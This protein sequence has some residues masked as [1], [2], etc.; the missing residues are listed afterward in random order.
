MK[1]NSRFAELNL[2]IKG[3][4]YFLA[5]DK[6]DKKMEMKNANLLAKTKMAE[7]L[8]PRLLPKVSQANSKF[9]SN[10]GKQKANR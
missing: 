8:T 7:T 3:T 4:W 9:S 5:K 2:V 1:D 6:L 10:L